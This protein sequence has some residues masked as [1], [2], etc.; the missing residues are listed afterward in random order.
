MRTGAA[1]RQQAA[2]AAVGAAHGHARPGRRAGHRAERP[3]RG[4]G[5]DR[6]GLVQ[7][8]R[9]GRLGG[10]Q[11][12][13]RDHRSGH[14]QPGGGAR[15]DRRADRLRHAAHAHDP[16]GKPGCGVTPAISGFVP[17]MAARR[18]TYGDMSA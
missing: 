16:P 17:R 4:A 18:T 10:H 7:P 5:H 12:A 1:L 14:R 15:P 2:G 3:G 6:R 11:R 8:A 13:R 9:G